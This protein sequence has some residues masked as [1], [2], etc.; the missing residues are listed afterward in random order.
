MEA[1]APLAVKQWYT[2]F[3]RGGALAR[4]LALLSALSTGYVAYNR[5]F[6]SSLSHSHPESV[7]T[8]RLTRPNRGTKFHIFPPESCL[9][10]PSSQ[11][12]AFYLARDRPYKQ[13]AHGQEGRPC[14][15]VTGRQG[16]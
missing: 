3:T 14:I 9:H 8:E 5:M 4:P 2:L 13:Q 10:Y 16:Y 1:P 12:C 6:S 15:R 7:A 11:H